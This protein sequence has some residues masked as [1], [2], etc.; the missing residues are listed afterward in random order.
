[1]QNPSPLMRGLSAL[2]IA[3]L[4]PLPALAQDARP[5]VAASSPDGTITLTVTTDS[6]ARAKYSLSRKGKLLIAPSSLGFLLSDGLNMVRGFR[7]EGSA[8]A[9]GSDRWE[10]P[11]GERRFVTDHYNELVVRFR[12]S[13]V[14]GARAMNVRFRLFD[15]G[16]GLRYEIPEQ[17][18]FKTMRIAEELTEFTIALHE[19]E[20]DRIGR[21]KRTDQQA[22]RI[23]QRSPDPLAIGGMQRHAVGIVNFR[24]VII[25]DGP[26][27]FTEEEH[28]GQ[29]R[30]AELADSF[31]QVQSR[32]DVDGGFH[33]RL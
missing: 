23:G 25:G 27:V 18:A 6:D 14:Q 8:T 33:T 29:G 26:L 10:Q 9:S 1:M 13:D 30:D 31:A 3:F 32:F 12:Q 7:I 15:N 16:F 22:F 4:A 19:A 11:W 2:A 17:P 28:A 21:G 24:P 20:T 5:A